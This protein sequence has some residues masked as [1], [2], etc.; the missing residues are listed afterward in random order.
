DVRMTATEQIIALPGYLGLNYLGVR[1]LNGKQ[2]DYFIPFE[3]KWKNRELSVTRTSNGG[4]YLVTGNIL[5]PAKVIFNPVKANLWY[6]EGSARVGPI[7]TQGS[8]GGTTTPLRDGTYEISVPDEPHNAGNT[9]LSDSSYARLW[10]PIPA[11]Q[12]GDGKNDDRFLH[13][14]SNS[15]GCVTVKTISQWT[16]I[17][18]YLYNRRLRDDVI[19]TITVSSSFTG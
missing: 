4:S 3:G 6:G 1:V 19:G 16:G 8:G 18:R 15:L 10:Y 2:R 5:G 7:F 9:Y 17:Y 12:D 13:C 11:D 14:G